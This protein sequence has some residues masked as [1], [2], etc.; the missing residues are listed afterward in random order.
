MGSTDE[1]AREF[2]GDIGQGVAGHGDA[3][4]AGVGRRGAPENVNRDRNELDGSTA[5]QSEMNGR[6]VEKSQAKQPEVDLGEMEQGV[7]LDVL[8]KRGANN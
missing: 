4:H 5:G 2:R 3:G 7:E 1:R 6:K 8:P